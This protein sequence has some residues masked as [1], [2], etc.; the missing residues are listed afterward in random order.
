MRTIRVDDG[1]AQTLI[2]NTSLWESFPFLKAAHTRMANIKPPTPKCPVCAK[3]A[4]LQDTN[5][6][7][8]EVRS[9]ICML[10]PDK[11]K[12]LKQALHADELKVTIITRK[13]PETYTL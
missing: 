1:V 13:G 10:T 7:L 3:K 12:I 6:I 11:R 5:A 4:V 2:K 8:E 9:R